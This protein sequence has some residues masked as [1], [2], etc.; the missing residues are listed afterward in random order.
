MS[1]FV[2]IELE[3]RAQCKPPIVAASA[4]QHLYIV[5]RVIPAQSATRRSPKAKTGLYLS[6]NLIYLAGSCRPPN[7]SSSHNLVVVAQS[8]SKLKKTSQI[9]CEMCSCS[10]M[11]YKELGWR[12]P[13]LPDWTVLRR[14]IK[15]VVDE[16]DLRQWMSH[17]PSKS[18]WAHLLSSFRHCLHIAPRIS[19]TVSAGTIGCL[20]ERYNVKK[21]LAIEQALT[22][23]S[24]EM[25]ERCDVTLRQPSNGQMSPVLLIQHAAPCCFVHPSPPASRRLV[26]RVSQIITNAISCDCSRSSALLNSSSAERHS[27]EAKAAAATYFATLCLLWKCS[28]RRPSC[29]LAEQVL[30]LSVGTAIRQPLFNVIGNARQEWLGKQRHKLCCWIS[31][32][33]PVFRCHRTVLEASSY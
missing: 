19:E 14:L 24:A 12:V 20:E 15:G 11:R 25:E 28:L 26:F 5:V 13:K 30:K 17:S 3:W 2:N 22:S 33:R 9:E 23:S 29:E 1:C 32:L 18:A 10:H 31:S 27:P 21:R 16:S 7:G 8:L 6:S 4:R